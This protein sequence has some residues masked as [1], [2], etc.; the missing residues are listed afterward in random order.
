LS[1]SRR[2]LST[3]E[4]AKSGNRKLAK[5]L[6]SCSILT[7][8]SQCI[9]GDDY[10][11]NDHFALRDDLL[12]LLQAGRQVIPLDWLLDALDGSR[13]YTDLEARRVIDAG[14]LFGKGL[15]SDDWWRDTDRRGFIAIENHGCRAA[16]G[17]EPGPVT[18]SSDRSN[19]PRSVCGRDWKSAQELLALITA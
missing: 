15:I 8:H 17:A 14:S 7:Y 2:Q 4:P 18:P 9:S 10:A 13:P 19:L 16:L 5:S 11:H 12:V 1:F 6:L 3:N